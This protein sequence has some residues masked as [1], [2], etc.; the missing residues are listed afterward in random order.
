MYIKTE[1]GAFEWDDAKADYNFRKHGV[2]FVDAIQIFATNDVLTVDDEGHYYGETREISIGPVAGFLIVTV[3][4]TARNETTRII[5]ARPA[6]RKD[7]AR[8]AAFIA[9]RY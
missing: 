6:D 5:S 7:R 1:F 8:F 4:H 9:G 3:V 2:R